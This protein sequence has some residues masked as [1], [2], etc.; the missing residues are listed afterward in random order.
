M[1]SDTMHDEGTPV[2]RPNYGY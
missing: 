2:W 1:S